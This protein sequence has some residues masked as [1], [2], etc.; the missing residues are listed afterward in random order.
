MPYP[1]QTGFFNAHLNKGS[2]MLHPGGAE[3]QAN[4]EHKA[5]V[6][7]YKA[8]EKIGDARF[9]V[10]TLPGAQNGPKSLVLLFQSTF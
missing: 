8:T 7:D 1:S 2:E 10:E 6:E 5:K 4:G 3:Q 9:T